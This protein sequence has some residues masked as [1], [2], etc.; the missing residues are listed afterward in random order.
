MKS[1][2]NPH[3]IIVSGIHVELTQALKAY[4]VDKMQRLF[5]H[6]GQIVRIRVE[7][8][9]DDRK[10]KEDRFTA[11]AHVQIHGPDA[12]ISVTSDDAY[13]SIDLLVDKLDRKILSRASIHKE[14]RNHPHEVELETTLPKVG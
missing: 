4:V 10:A 3:E 11:K 1:D 5:T 2:T 14:K 9:F 13:K 12:N 7:I 8:E 6:E